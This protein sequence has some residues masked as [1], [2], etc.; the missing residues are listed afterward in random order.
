MNRWQ[1]D[2]ILRQ[3]RKM[4]GLGAWLAAQEPPTDDYLHD[5]LHEIWLRIHVRRF[6]GDES[7]HPNS[8][9]AGVHYSESV[10]EQIGREMGLPNVRMRRDRP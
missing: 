3:A 1:R 5:L 9:Y 6:D 2:E 7:G 8:Y 10:V 4:P